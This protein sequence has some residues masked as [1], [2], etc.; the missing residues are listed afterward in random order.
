MNDTEYIRRQVEDFKSATDYELTTEDCFPAWYIA[1]TYGLGGKHALD[2]CSTPVADGGKRGDEGL[3]AFYYDG[4]TSKL[5]LIQA[6]FTTEMSQIVQ[7]CRDLE[8]ALPYVKKVIEG[9]TEARSQNR[10]YANLKAALQRNGS[11]IG[12]VAITSFDLRVIHLLDK[13]QGF[14]ESDCYTAMESVKDTFRSLFPAASCCEFHVVGPQEIRKIVEPGPREIH[15]NK[16][17]VSQIPE[18]WFPLRLQPLRL[19]VQHG[20]CGVTMF[21]GVGYLA[22]LVE[23]YNRR[24]DMLFERNV[25]FYLRSKKNEDR[26]PAGKITETLKEICVFPTEKALDPG[27]F[28]F[29]H[30][31]ITVLAE[32]V[33][34]VEDGKIEVREP[35]VLN[36]CQTIKTSYYFLRPEGKFQ[37]RIDLER[38]NRIQVPLRII[39]TKDDGLIRLIAVNNNRQNPIK[40]ADLRANDPEQITLFER[41]KAG[42]IFYERQEGAFAEREEVD[43]RKLQDEFPNTNEMCANI[44]DIARCLAAT[45]G[46]LDYASSPSHIFET[47]SEYERVFSDKRLK[48]LTLLVFLQNLSNV[49]PVVLRSELTYDPPGPKVGRI[50]YHVMC[51]L[52]RRLAKHHKDLVVEYG[53]ELFPK[54]HKNFTSDLVAAVKPI[55]ATVQQKMLNSLPDKKQE[56]ISSAFAKLERELRLQKDIDV[57]DRFRDL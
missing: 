40:A 47:D 5:V 22:D 10:I 54:R 14:V 25:R 41:F 56:T 53:K 37:Q 9:V 48:S 43:L 8:R 21:S 6:K 44:E 26:G 20:K 4:Q 30:N 2:W 23:C 51:L 45:A 35:Y 12:Q 32:D 17:S 18:Q 19:T 50:T 1:S 27:M 15:K 34:E 29:Y 24:R 46:E 42:G 28:A 39:T 55:K 38:W 49:L 57:F 36:G 7:G 11:N 31:G 52:M 13:D 33:R 16:V 3:D